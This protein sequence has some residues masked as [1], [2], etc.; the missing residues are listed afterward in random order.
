MGQGLKGADV[1]ESIVKQAMQTARRA[2][3]VALLVGAVLVVLL[4]AERYFFHQSSSERTI[5][6]QQ[7]LKMTSQI[8]LLNERMEM[9]AKLAAST[10]DMSWVSN[11]ANVVNQ[12]DELIVQTLTLASTEL[13][14]RF[15]TQ[16]QQASE[17]AVQFERRVFELVE[18]G[19]LTAA[20]RLLES[21]AYAQQKRV[22]IEGLERFITELSEEKASDAR[23]VVARSQTL[24]PLL[25]IM[26]GLVL[27]WALKRSLRSAEFSFG[28]AEAQMVR[29]AMTDPLTG[30]PNRRAFAQELDEVVRQS[31]DPA[32]IVAVLSV[33]LD[34]FKRI[35][36]LYGHTVG[37]EVLNRVAHRIVQ[38]LPQ[39][40]SIARFSG[41]EF[42]V[43]MVEEDQKGIDDAAILLNRAV[44]EPI[45]SRQDDIK[46]GACIGIAQLTGAEIGPKSAA[47]PALD[48]VRMASIALHEAKLAGVGEVRY[49]SQ[50]LDQNLRDKALIEAELDQALN[51]GDIVP[52]FQPIVN[53]Q[54]GQLTGF[55]VLARWQRSDQGMVPPDKFV[56]MAENLGRI[57]DLTE[58]VLAKSLI[59]AKA[60]DQRLTLSI[61]VTAKQIVDFG[62]P[63]MIAALLKQHNWPSKRLIV[64]VTEDS[65]VED[66]VCASIVIEALREQGIKVALDDFGAGYS[67]F[68]HLSSLT[69][70]RLKIDR[71]F[72]RDLADNKEDRT[73]VKSI[74]GMSQNLNIETVAEGIETAEAGKQLARMG[75]P[76]GQGYHYSK[77]VPSSAAAALIDQLGV[78]QAGRTRRAVRS[79]SARETSLQTA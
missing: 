17:L 11:H 19:R 15:V 53:L 33:N 41:D 21:A 62:L 28:K 77:P 8:I 38:Y 76:L 64:E 49:Y 14:E 1:N 7:A 70:D 44:C 78:S 45:M 57:T 10:G 37:D 67:S 61:N 69:F 63:S 5:E 43:A 56:P 60:W 71:K 48:L 46:M 32:S 18:D 20:R 26:C 52:F 12:M 2:V 59:A 30:L 35:N 34:R 54:D 16:T 66:F 3:H 65:L 42:V 6:A 75:C 27:W 39:A 47:Q 9:S 72:V 23:A 68:S 29:L 58:S 50:K 79:L 22:L 40:K 31:I 24:I 73:I 55:E 4:L 36:D 13:A 25:I 74:I 51:Q